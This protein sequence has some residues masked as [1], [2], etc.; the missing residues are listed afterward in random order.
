MVQR[1][2]RKSDTHRLTLKYVHIETFCALCVSLCMCTCGGC[3]MLQHTATYCNLLQHFSVARAQHTATG[4]GALQ[5]AAICCHTLQHT[6][7]YCNTLQHFAVARAPRVC[8]IEKR[9][10]QEKLCGRMRLSTSGMGTVYRLYTPAR[11]HACISHAQPHTETL[12][13]TEC[14]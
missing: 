11:T 2:T 5:H 9:E 12:T 13:H 1:P 6:A 8:E 10:G 14:E 4:L 3:N 7:T